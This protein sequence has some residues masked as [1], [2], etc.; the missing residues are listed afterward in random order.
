MRDCLFLLMHFVDSAI[1]DVSASGF[2]VL[3]RCSSIPIIR[4]EWRASRLHQLCRYKS[5]G[6]INEE[7][8]WFGPNGRLFSCPSCSTV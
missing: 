2:L 8:L 6:R 7:A 1:R 5:I 4:L 3:V